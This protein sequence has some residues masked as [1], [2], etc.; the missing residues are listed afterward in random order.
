MITYDGGSNGMSGRQEL[1]VDSHN[2]YARLY[3]NNSSEQ[4]P[5]LLDAQQCKTLA[6]QL[7]I[8]AEEQS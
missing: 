7:L 3:T 8:I 4:T 1:C 5:V 6:A 2:G